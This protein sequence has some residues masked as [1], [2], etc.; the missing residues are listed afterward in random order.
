MDSL[1]P[2]EFRVPTAFSSFVTFTKRNE[3]VYV[4]SGLISYS[5]LIREIF[6]FDSMD[7]VI[8]SM[9]APLESFNYLLSEFNNLY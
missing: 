1:F 5:T 6:A 2:I 3:L 4:F 8:N 9:D 7:R